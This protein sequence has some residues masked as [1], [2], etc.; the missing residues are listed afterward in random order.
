MRKYKLSLVTANES[1]QAQRTKAETFTQ[2]CF[3]PQKGYNGRF[4]RIRS[5]AS[6]FDNE[7]AKMEAMAENKDT[8]FKFI[9]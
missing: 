6:V 9:G 3:Q 7:T 2:T 5:N 1:H 8:S 4:G